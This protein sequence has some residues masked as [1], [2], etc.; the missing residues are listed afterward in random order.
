MTHRSPDVAPILF[1][2]PGGVPT[3]AVAGDSEDASRIS[4]IP[5]ETEAPAPGQSSPPAAPPA[6]A[7]IPADDPRLVAFARAA[8]ELGAAR[9]QVL[10]SVEGQLLELAVAIA[11]SVI[12]RE[13]EVDPELHGSLARAALATLG[14]APGARLRASRDAH[15]AIVAVFGSP[16]VTMDG[17][18]VQVTMD[19][20]LEGLGC[21]AE[22][23]HTRVDGRI[24]ERLRAVLRS[25]EDER[26]RGTM[27]DAG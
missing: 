26:R 8:A 15:A 12:D 7:S 24:G 25:L 3:I 13:I 19:P 20:A 2:G 11:S 1:P 18:T 27:E 22:N 14:S 23:E 16:T 17:L 9:A 21:I 6:P 5:M 4:D 10:S